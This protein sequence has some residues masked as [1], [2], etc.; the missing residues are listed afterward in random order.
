[1]DARRS[2]ARFAPGSDR[3]EGQASRRSLARCGRAAEGAWRRV[4]EMYGTLRA[5]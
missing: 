1:M 5:H 2:L 4:W 3:A